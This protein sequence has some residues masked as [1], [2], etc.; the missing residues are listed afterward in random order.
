MFNKFI[1]AITSY[2]IIYKSVVGL[3]KKYWRNNDDKTILEEVQS[4]LEGQ[5]K[6]LNKYL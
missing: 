3:R 1:K 5:V 2:P 6:V 4:E